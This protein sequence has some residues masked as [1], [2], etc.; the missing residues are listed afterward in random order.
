MVTPSENSFDILAPWEEA[1]AFKVCN[2]IWH[3]NSV[4]SFSNLLESAHFHVI[5]A[6]IELS[7]AFSAGTLQCHLLVKQA[8]EEREHFVGDGSLSAEVRREA[9]SGGHLAEVGIRGGQDELLELIEVKQLVH[10]AI[11]LLDY[12]FSVGHPRI[13]ELLAHVVIELVTGQ[14]SVVIDIQMLE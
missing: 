3:L 14:L 9:S 6:Q 2:Q 4:I 8:G 10:S 13:Q 12:S 11:V 1:I 5:L 7:L